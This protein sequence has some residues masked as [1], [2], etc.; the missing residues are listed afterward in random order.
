MIKMIKSIK[1]RFGPCHSL[2]A[3]P[4]RVGS[5]PCGRHPAQGCADW[6]PRWLPRPWAEIQT[7]PAPRIQHCLECWTSYWM[8]RLVRSQP[9]WILRRSFGRSFPRD[10]PFA[11]VL[12]RIH[13]TYFMFFGMIPELWFSPGFT[14][15]LARFGPSG[16][17]SKRQESR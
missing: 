6:D 3:L 17:S 15:V 5:F 1:S 14:T 16:C 13:C 7:T 8:F 2:A 12:Q 4:C 10:W 9:F 11:D